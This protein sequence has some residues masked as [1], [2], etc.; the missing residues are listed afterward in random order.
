MMRTGIHLN[1]KFFSNEILME[2]IRYKYDF[3]RYGNWIKQVK[4]SL[5]TEFSDFGFTLSS[6]I[7]R[8]I[9]YHE[10]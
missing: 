2:T 4:T 10:R 7:V 8:E 1:R 5:S 3:D 6:V 9:T